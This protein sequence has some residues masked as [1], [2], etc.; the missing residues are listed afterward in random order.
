MNPRRLR[1]VVAVAIALGL[2]G[3][4][5]AQDEAGQDPAAICKNPQCPGILGAW[6][7]DIAACAAKTAR[8]RELDDDVGKLQ[9]KL[10]TCTTK[11]AD[12]E[13][14]AAR[15]QAEVDLLKKAAGPDAGQLAKA[16]AAAKGWQSEVERLRAEKEKLQQQA[17]SDVAALRKEVERLRLGNGKQRLP[18]EEDKKQQPPVAEA[19]KQ[20]EASGQAQREEG[21]CV[22]LAAAVK[23]VCFVRT[24]APGWLMARSGDKADRGSTLFL[25]AFIDAGV[26]PRLPQVTAGSDCGPLRDVLKS[27][28]PLDPRPSVDAVFVRSG[29]AVGQCYD[30]GEGDWKVRPVSKSDRKQQAWILVPDTQADGGVRP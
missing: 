9:G 3:R 5:G 27:L 17:D 2:L 8:V 24:G 12:A 11:A 21:G 22:A 1:A 10:A 29:D 15:L 6:Q 28:Q 14:R 18:T 16:V 25:R 26:V 23:G 13:D 7:Q 20:P 19:K 30:A 4:A